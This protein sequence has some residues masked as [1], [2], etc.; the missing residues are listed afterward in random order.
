M[1]FFAMST[2]SEEF[3]YTIFVQQVTPGTNFDLR[4]IIREILVQD[5]SRIIPVPVVDGTRRT[6]TDRALTLAYHEHFVHRWAKIQ[7]RQ[8][9]QMNVHEDNSIKLLWLDRVVRNTVF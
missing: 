1:R 2:F 3:S 7:V 8:S 4:L 9:I 6:M 5:L